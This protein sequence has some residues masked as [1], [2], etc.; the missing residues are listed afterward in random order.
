MQREYLTTLVAIESELIANLSTDGADAV[1]L[2]RR[3]DVIEGAAAQLSKET[4]RTCI[5][6]AGD[7]RDPKALKEAVRQAIEKFGRL[8]FVICGSFEIVLVD[9]DID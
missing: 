9:V 1:I 6:V 2:G 7:V 3:K 4:G 8:D 5:G